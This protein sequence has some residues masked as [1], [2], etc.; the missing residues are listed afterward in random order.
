MALFEQDDHKGIVHQFKQIMEQTKET[1]TLQ[2]RQD[3]INRLGDRRRHLDWHVQEDVVAV[4]DLED[5]LKK[6]CEALERC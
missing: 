1:E 5:I 6:V 4:Y 2:T 3:R